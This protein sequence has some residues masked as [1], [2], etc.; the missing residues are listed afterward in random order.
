MTAPFRS[1]VVEGLTN[2]CPVSP[3]TLAVAATCT[4]NV[5]FKPSTT[6]LRNG[7]VMIS[8]NFPGSPQNVNLTGAGVAPIVTLGASSVTFAN[9]IVGTNSTAQVV[10]L[11]NTGTSTLNFTGAGITITGANSGDFS[12]TNTCGASVAAGAMCNINVVFTPTATGSRSA[13][14]SINDDATGSPQSVPLTGTGVAPA[15]T[16]SATNVSFG[17]Q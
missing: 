6:G 1:P 5:A 15:V 10:G 8:Y 4:V 16:L 3:A 11:T 17:N 12:Q 13:S 9:Q 7:A 14:L 2:T